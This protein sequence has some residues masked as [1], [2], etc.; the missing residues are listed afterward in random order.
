[1]TSIFGATILF[2]PMCILARQVEKAREVHMP[3]GS[4]A[5]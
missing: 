4:S 1:M 5:E 3:L 2:E